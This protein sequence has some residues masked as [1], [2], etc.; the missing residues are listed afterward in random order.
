MNE[1]LKIEKEEEATGRELGMD[2]DGDGAPPPPERFGC[3][4]G[5]GRNERAQLY[6]MAVCLPACL[7][8]VGWL[9]GAASSTSGRGP[10]GDAV[11]AL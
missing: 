3:G 5:L 7:S 8:R 4:L 1:N 2:G 9:A 10:D 11:V 6:G